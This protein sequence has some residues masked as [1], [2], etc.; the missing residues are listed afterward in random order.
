MVLGPITQGFIDQCI[1]EFKKEENQNKIK[2]SIV[3][4][5]TD[6]FQAKI[7]RYVQFLGLIMGIMI[8]LLVTILFLFV[9]SSGKPSAVTPM[10]T[11]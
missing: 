2:A 11:S 9:R 5:L 6:Y 10:I 1:V 3:D 4:P 8:L 7:F